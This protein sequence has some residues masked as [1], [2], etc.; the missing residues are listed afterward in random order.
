[1]A[2]DLTAIYR[3]LTD[4]SSLENFWQL[5]G[6]IFGS[7]YDRPLAEI[8]R[9]QW[10]REDF[11]QLPPIRVLESG[12][13]GIAGAYSR[14]DNTI[15][16]SQSFLDTA[17]PSQII[18]V[19][20]EEIGHSVDALINQQDSQGDEGELFSA[21]VRGISLT[22][23]E[24]QG[25]QAQD[26]T[27]TILV[28]D[29][30]LAVET[31]TPNITLS[32]SPAVVNEDGTTNL[33]YTFSRTDTTTA[34]SVNFTVSG[35]ATF[36]SDYTQSGA[37]SFSATTGTINFAQNVGTVTL[38][39]NPTADLG[40]ENNETIALS[41]STG[42]GYTIGTP[43]PVTGIIANDDTFATSQFLL[44]DD[45]TVKIF[46]SDGSV[47]T[48][49]TDTTNLNYYPYGDSSRRQ[50]GWIGW[51]FATNWVGSG[52]VQMGNPTAGIDAGNYL[53]VA[54]GGKAALDRNF[55]GALSQGGLKVSFGMAPNAT[56]NIDQSVWGSFNL[57]LSS[58]D[59]LSAVNAAANHFGILFRGN[60]GIQAFDGNLDVT[61]SNLVSNPNK[62]WGGTS[63]NGTLYPFSV[64][65]TD[66]TDNNPFNG[67]GQTNIDIYANETL[68]YSYVKGGGGYTDNYFNF[69]G[70]SVTGVDN[71]KIERLN[72][73]LKLT[74]GGATD[75]LSLALPFA[76]IANV[77]VTL[78]GG[79]QLTTNV[80]TL[81]FTPTN[82]NVPQTVTVSAV[83]D[84]LGEGT[85]QGVIS[86]VT[87]SDGG[88]YYE[89]SMIQSVTV[90]ITDNDLV[91]TGIRS[92]VAQTGNSNPFNG[93]DV[94]YFSKPTLVDVNRD[95]DLD[96]IIG[97]SDGKVSYYEN[98][99]SSTNPIF[100][101]RTGDPYN[102]SP[103]NPYNAFWK[104]YAQDDF[105]S[106]AFADLNGDGDP[107]LVVGAGDGTFSYYK[108][109]YSDYGYLYVSRY[110][111][112]DDRNPFYGLDLGGLTSPAFADLDGDGDP[113]FVAGTLDGK[114]Q[115]FKNT[116]SAINTLQSTINPNFVAQVGAANPFNNIA[117]G[118]NNTPTFYDVDNDGDFDLLIGEKNGSL[119]YYKNIGTAF[120]P[121]FEAQANSLFYG[122]SAGT[123]VSPALGDLN[124]DGVLD[125]VVGSNDGTL[126]Y[127]V[128][129]PVTPPPGPTVSFN[130]TDLNIDL[131]GGT[132][133]PVAFQP[134]LISLPK[135]NIVSGTTTETNS[136]LV[137]QENQII[138]GSIEL[139]NLVIG[140]FSISNPNYGYQF[141]TYLSSSQLLSQLR[142]ISSSQ[143]SFGSGDYQYLASLVALE[144][145]A[146]AT[147]ASNDQGTLQATLL[148]L[149]IQAANKPESERTD[150]EK[151]GL[152]WLA[153]RVKQNRIAEAQ[154]ALDRYNY[155][156][157]HTYTRD[158][159]GNLLADRY[160]TPQGFGFA[161]Y[162]VTAPSG[163]AA[164]TGSPYPPDVRRDAK[165]IVHR[166][167][168]L[169][170]SAQVSTAITAKGLTRLQ[171]ESLDSSKLLQSLYAS[172]ADKSQV[173]AIIF[174]V[175]LGTGVVIAAGITAATVTTL[176][177]ATVGA[178]LGP[179]ALVPG[180]STIVSLAGTNLAAGTTILSA[181]TTS[182]S[183]AI[184]A[185]AIS[186]GPIVVVLAGAA[187]AAGYGVMLFG[188]SA[189]GVEGTVNIPT[190]LQNELTTARNTTVDL[191]THL[192]ANK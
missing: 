22:P 157:N 30:L 191:K 62:S 185:F 187:A 96:L 41:L 13:D 153:N 152:A 102:S 126:Q 146:I 148:N 178:S 108:N 91:T 61:N 69:G 86:V 159:R 173:G 76:P 142:I 28:G 169:D 150:A 34:L 87:S 23:E 112:N 182:V 158:Q 51:N 118:A 47:F 3:Y 57:G 140:D 72:K 176:A 44:S 105:S 84:A 120:A 179:I 60:G 99:G 81:T 165:A 155:W 116:G 71:F 151:G 171:Q 136:N 161:N 85:H 101:Q 183:S 10:Q 111:A 162:D 135:I 94:G 147:A 50:I 123:Y 192:Q 2:V 166:T 139:G 31:A 78:D 16:L 5:F 98:I 29:R 1:M 24:I 190:N 38:T 80:S 144:N 55:N 35:T 46:N 95:G 66:P 167:L 92:Y 88:N 42:T 122:I 68:I 163:L 184:S 174:G 168:A 97:R 124:G 110:S 36:N 170:P 172:G 67:V 6:T 175:G 119:N 45:F 7:F 113:D 14:S 15:Y 125:V 43:T 114:L 127:F 53:L 143:L 73:V 12:M 138:F 21:F 89:G 32:V 93:I 149:L 56:G 164:L 70:L 58:A 54:G 134:L 49:T 77:T 33:I 106:P 52:N 8:L 37:A 25:V 181:D 160:Q 39:I 40:I 19:I 180:V 48:G 141:N 133:A 129:L 131:G 103:T 115:Y 64:L 186:T 132:L 63:N 100:A 109:K 18:A 9:S 4:F 11:S 83:N 188:S 156:T 26:D 82:W 145:Q 17:P 75:T 130:G 90:S 65:L 74:E 104:V 117:V 59:K 137:V 177:V 121:I 27:N 154:T 128:S 189:F 79:A 107:D 20:L